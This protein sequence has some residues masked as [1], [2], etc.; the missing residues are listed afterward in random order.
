MSSYTDTLE[1]N[2]DRRKRKRKIP[3][4]IWLFDGCDGSECALHPVPEGSHFGPGPGEFRD[5]AVCSRK[6]YV[7]SFLAM[8]THRTVHT[9]WAGDRGISHDEIRYPTSWI[10]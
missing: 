7:A 1:A 3:A 5:P 2:E 8:Q 10:P 4:I 9:L 6:R